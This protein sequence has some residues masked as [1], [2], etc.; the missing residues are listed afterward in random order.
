LGCY[1]EVGGSVLDVIVLSDPRNTVKI[2]LVKL[3]DVVRLTVKN[4]GQVEKKFGKLDF[5]C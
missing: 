1:I 5:I 3:Y 2:P 4:L